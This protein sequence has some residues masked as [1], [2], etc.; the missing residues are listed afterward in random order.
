M[1]DACAARTDGVRGRGPG[2]E[3]RQEKCVRS[4]KF[5]AKSNRIRGLSTVRRVDGAADQEPG[6]GVGGVHPADP[7]PAW[8]YADTSDI[9]IYRNLIYLNQEQGI[10]VKS[11]MED[12]DIS[13]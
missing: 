9:Y 3:D 12:S 1:R 2:L 11:D 4:V 5:E 7:H 8:T 13:T 6:S 10:A